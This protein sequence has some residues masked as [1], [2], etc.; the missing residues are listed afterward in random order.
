M[1]KKLLLAALLTLPTHAIEV[2]SLIPIAGYQSRQDNLITC[3]DGSQI[4]VEFLTPDMPRI[5]MSYKKRLEPNPSWAIAKTDWAP[6]AVSTT[7]SPENVTVASAQLKVIIHKSPLLI[8]I[9]DRNGRTLSKDA[10]PLLGDPNHTQKV[11]DPSAGFMT[12]VTK[13]LGLDEH[14]YALGEKAHK[15]DRRR[16]HFRMFNSDTPKYSEGTDPIYQSIP[17]YIS[18]EDNRAHGLF[19]DNSYRSH[20]DF[21]N[22]GQEFTGYGVEGGQIDYYFI[23]GPSIKDV[24]RRYTELTGRIYLPPKWALGHQASRWSYYPDRMVEKIA[25]TYQQHDLP[26]DVMTL[27]IDYMQKYRVFTWDLKRF[28]D[29]DGL[30]RRLKA[31]GLHI[32][33]IVDP[34]VKYQ[35]QGVA[36]AKDQEQPE[37]KDQSGSYYV[38]NQGSKND[39]F[40]K[41]KDGK[42]MVTTVWPGETVFVDFTKEAARKWW[43][44][45]HRAYLDHGTGGIWNDMNEP[46]DFT[47]KGDTGANQRDSYFDDLGRNTPH[48]KNRNVFALLMCKATY[49]GLLRL[50]PNDRPYV[51]TRAAYAGIQRYSTMWTGD[52]ASSWEALAVSVPMFC[53]LGLSGETF[54]G[55]DVGGFMGRGDGE[56]LTRAYQISF[57]VPFCRN[58]KAQDDYDQEP[59]R[60][61]T[62][63]ENII[64]KYLKLRYRLLPYIYA[65]LDE[66]RTT[67]TPFI[68]PLVLEYQDDSNTYAMDD[69]FLAGRDLLCSPV[70]KPNQE[71]KRVYLPRGLWYDFYTGKLQSKQNQV[72]DAP[73]ETVPLYARGGSIVPL[74][75]EKNTVDAL[76]NGA[77]E[78]RVYPNAA[79]KAEGTLYEDDGKSQQY[80]HGGFARRKVSFANRT[81]TI[82]KTG[83]ALPQRP[84][85]VR[86][87]NTKNQ[88]ATVDGKPVPVRYYPNYIEVQTSDGPH[89]IR[90]I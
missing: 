31:K 86:F 66:A 13:E 24:V 78:L 18:L 54:I 7:E 11:F 16:G 64:R 59:W 10:R 22:S 53:N 38:Y 75:P 35:P 42:Q 69:Q 72:V 8:E 3:Q 47:E 32:V 83:Y 77:L 67:G 89:V 6:T 1:L 51:I 41:R 37:L 80:L 87:Y 85:H 63:Y 56:M 82:E 5:Q 61:G 2:E 9:Q 36:S 81:L 40:V 73:L 52:A 62:Y 25:D 70:V 44:D 21:G 15:L 19:Y 68:R 55:S 17:F 84:L 12:V 60:F 27:D 90:L 45:M 23:D 28:A 49:E 39:Y 88:S 34:G 74:G 65:G 26:L 71:K 14:F 46:A 43:G 4:K 79:Q 50:R 58:H 20:F 48:A 76:P 57:L 29:P 33:N 30:A